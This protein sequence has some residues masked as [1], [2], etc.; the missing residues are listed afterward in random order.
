VSAPK[1][2]TVTNAGTADLDVLAESFVG[3]GASD[4]FVGA[5]TC[6]GAV[7]AGETCSIWVH[8]APQGKEDARATLVLKTNAT[9][10]NY[11]V[12]LRGLAGA[13]PQGE[14]G[15]AGAPGT[16]GTN[17]T[18]GTPGPAGPAGPQGPKGDPGAGLTGAKITCKR[19]MVRRGR[20]SVRCTLR[21]AVAARVRAARVTV[22]RRGRPVVRATGFARRGS[23]RIV[24]PIGV[25]PREI[26]VAT[27]DRAGRLR[28][29]RTKVRR[30]G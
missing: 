25:R 17:G 29:T 3:A 26:G 1:E 23:V 28:T 16:N 14:P 2:V 18:N 9:P 30:A 8:F 5:S 4:F 6:R 12:D 10:A 11:E 22:R 19:A 24:L 21:L 27:I 20:V 7:P 13:L 15:Q